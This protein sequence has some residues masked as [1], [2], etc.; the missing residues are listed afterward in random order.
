MADVQAPTAPAAPAPVGSALPRNMQNRLAAMEHSDPTPVAPALPAAPAVTTPDPVVATEGTVTLSR[1]EYNDLQ[2]NAGKTQAA[3][4]R[5]EN[6]RLQREDMSHRL[7]ELEN[8][9]KSVS[10]AAPSAP[11]PAI[12]VEAV[13]F[14]ADEEKDFGDSK[15]Y[16]SK[17]VKAQLAPVMGTINAL[18]TE[19]RTKITAAEQTASG[20]VNTVQKAT[21]DSFLSQVHAAV[22]NLEAIKQHKNWGDYLDETDELSGATIEQLLAHNIHKGKIGPVAKIYKRFEEKYMQGATPNLAGYNGAAPSGGGTDLQA[23]PAVQG[24]LKQSDRRR[25]SEDYRKGK[26]TWEQLQVVNA[27]FDEADKA[28]NIEFDK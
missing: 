5:A 24:K 25:A 21:A 26:I 22:P 27:K 15:E 8:R 28:G 13:E 4:A 11:A 18:I 1:Q 12:S 16:I 14:T 3:V 7:T 2:A 19:L 20:A 10:E 23:N 17:V 6:E 9:S